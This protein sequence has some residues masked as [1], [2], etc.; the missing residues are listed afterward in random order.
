VALYP[1]VHICFG[2]AS[3]SA[4]F[5]SNAAR[6]S[7]RVSHERDSANV[8]TLQLIDSLCVCF[9]EASND[10]DH[11]A[12]RYGR[13]LEALKKKLSVMSVSGFADPGAY[14]RPTLV[15]RLVVTLCPC[16]S[17]QKRLG[18]YLFPDRKTT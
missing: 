14:C 13:Q 6:G 7:R 3:Q 1:V 5:G 17:L 15:V 18:R 16:P 8:S 12:V 9:A 10:E 4:L 2:I 11:P